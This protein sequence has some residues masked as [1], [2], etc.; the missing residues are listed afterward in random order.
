LEVGGG[1]IIGIVEKH[2]EILKRLR[3]VAGG[4]SGQRDELYIFLKPAKSVYSESVCG[5]G[6]HVFLS[7]FNLAGA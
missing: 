1:V 6:A 2:P 3:G 5:G 4:V 7:P